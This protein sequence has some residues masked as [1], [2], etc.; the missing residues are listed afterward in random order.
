MHAFRGGASPTTHLPACP[1][2]FIIMDTM[3]LISRKRSSVRIKTDEQME[4]VEL[5]GK[6][7]QVRV[8]PSWWAR[9]WSG[10]GGRPSTPQQDVQLQE[11]NI[12][13]ARA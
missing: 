4:L 5:V 10:M 6:T 12:L 9:P 1:Q 8:R 11:N 13:V 7:M 2:G 3:E